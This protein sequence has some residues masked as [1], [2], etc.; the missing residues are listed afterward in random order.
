MRSSARALQHDDL[1]IARAEHAD[2]TVG[3]EEDLNLSAT[4]EALFP[5]FKIRDLRCR[6]V[7]LQLAPETLVDAVVAGLPRTLP[8]LLE[9]PQDDGAV[10]HSLRGGIVIQRLGRASRTICR[11]DSKTLEPGFP[12]AAAQPASGPH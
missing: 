12:F 4:R 3:Y 11:T 1:R 10:C 9:S 5:T 6:R 2:R 8:E 7:E